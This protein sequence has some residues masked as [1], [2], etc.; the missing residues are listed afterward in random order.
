MQRLLALVTLLT[1][2]VGIMGYAR[3]WFTFSSAPIGTDKPR[4]M[5]EVTPTQWHHD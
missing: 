4:V 5:M 3:G 2:G 1:V